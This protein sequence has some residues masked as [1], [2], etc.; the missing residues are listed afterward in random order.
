[1][2]KAKTM[3]FGK[4]KWKCPSCKKF[5]RSEIAKRCPKC[6]KAASKA[7]MADFLDPALDN[8]A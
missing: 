3:T 5:V 6:A 7:A 2:A 4:P 8:A 1:M